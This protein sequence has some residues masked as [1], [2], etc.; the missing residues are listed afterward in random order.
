MVATAIVGELPAIPGKY[1][2]DNAQTGVFVWR[3]IDTCIHQCAVACQV[4]RQIPYAV[5]L[6]TNCFQVLNAVTSQQLFACCCRLCGGRRWAKE[7]SHHASNRCFGFWHLPRQPAQLRI[8]HLRYEHLHNKRSL[9]IQHTLC[10]VTQSC[11]LD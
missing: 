8:H 11:T 7:T 10:S 3:H 6:L 4:G 9:N 5:A 2:T 1:V